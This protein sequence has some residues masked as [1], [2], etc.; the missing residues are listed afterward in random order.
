MN[1][2]KLADQAKQLIDKRG[3]MESVKE[4]AVELKN[5]A[6]EKAS[7]AKKVK[8]AGAALKDPGAPGDPAAP[9]AQSPPRKGQ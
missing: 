1:F 7:L 9:P 2:G 3:G 8:E 6:G 5:I 4:D